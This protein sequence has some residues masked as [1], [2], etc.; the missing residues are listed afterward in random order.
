[1]STIP[2]KITAGLDV[3]NGYVKGVVRGTDK[4]GQP[5]VDEIDLPSGVALVTRPNF[6]PT[7]DSEAVIET[8]RSGEASIFNQLDVSFVSPLVADQYRRIFGQR[9]LAAGG[10]FEEF[11]VTGHRSK[12]EQDLSKVLVMGLLAAKALKDHVRDAG[13]LPGDEDVLVVEARI[14]L[15]LP[16]TEFQ[17]HRH[18][19]AAAFKDHV[20][21][22][23]V[24]NFETPV[25]VKLKFV[26]VQV[27]AEGM[28]AQYAITAKGEPLMKVMLADVRSHGVAL[29]GITEA[30]VLAAQNTVGVD[31]GEGTVNFPVFTSG[32]PNVDS[33]ATLAKGYGQVLEAALESM[34]LQ[35][36]HSGFT[37]RK[38]LAAFLQAAPSPLKRGFYNK[39]KSYV[40]EQVVFFVREVARQFGDVLAVV[41]AQTEVVY[42]YGGGSGPIK[43]ELYPALLAKVVEMSGMSDSIPVLYLDARYSR[44]LNREGLFV[45]AEAVE[46]KQSAGAKKG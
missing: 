17:H 41:G 3:G 18:S 42:V 38:Q 10:S 22:V 5:V 6:V 31:V 34:E 14:A 29:D 46:R 2:S 26:D 23:T 9:A 20:H 45:A 32:R 36:F 7:P 33:S 16:I 15:A 28:S 11:N 43:D 1:M 35:G 40:D 8:Q 25:T 13:S 27:I 4:N 37:S 30:D 21:T 12:A 39:V 19:Y 44:H 24:H